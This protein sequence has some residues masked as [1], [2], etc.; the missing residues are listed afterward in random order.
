MSPI[1]VDNAV[2]IT[3]VTTPGLYFAFSTGTANAPSPMVSGQA[4]VTILGATGSQVYITLNSSGLIFSIGVTA[5]SSQLTLNCSFIQQML[6]ASCHLQFNLNASFSL[7]VPGTGE[8]I[9]KIA[10]NTTF[11]GTLG[12][13][14]SAAGATLS[15]SGNFDGRTLP[16]GSYTAP[17]NALQDVAV[18]VTNRITAQA[19][20]VFTDITLN[21]SKWASLVSSGVITDADKAKNDAS[22]AF[23]QA[24]SSLTSALTNAGNTIVKGVEGLGKDLGL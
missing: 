4:K 14:V 7:S 18:T 20:L 8:Y 13:E 23:G 21:P 12:L 6:N 19:E 11:T 5:G 15:L 24:W 9:G 10:V 17:T 22:S 16:G 1:S 3:G 2:S